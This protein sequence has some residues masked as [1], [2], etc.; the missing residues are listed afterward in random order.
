[1]KFSIFKQQTKDLSKDLLIFKGRNLK[2]INDCLSNNEIKYFKKICNVH[3]WGNKLILNIECN[4]LDT[5]ITLK[6]L[7]KFDNSKSSI[8]LNIVSE[9]LDGFEL[10]PYQD[11]IHNDKYLIFYK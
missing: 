1:M 5:P 6:D 10:I 11:F 8:E 9:D 2:H 7:L 3:S 4:K